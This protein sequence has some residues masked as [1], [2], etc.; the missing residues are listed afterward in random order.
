MLTDQEVEYAL[1][2][3][4]SKA[5]L[6]NNAAFLGSLLCSM[7]VIWKD[8]NNPTASTN[9]Q[10][11]WWNRDWFI[12]LPKETRVTVLVHELWHVGRLHFLRRGNRD[13]EIWN[14]ACDI[15]INNDLKAA[16]Y[17][18]KDIEWAWLMPELDVNGPMPEEDI[19]DHL[20]QNAKQPPPQPGEGGDGTGA[21]GDMNKDPDGDD[22]G[23]PTDEQA[24]K[25]NRMVEAVIRAQQAA[26]RANQAGSIPGGTKDWI[27]QFLT[28]KIKWETELMQFFTDLGEIRYTWARPNRRYVGQGE[29]RQSTEHESDRLEHLIYYLDVSGSIQ[30]KDRLRFNSEVKYIKDVLNPRKLT[31]VQFDTEIQHEHVFE[32]EDRFEKVVD[33]SGGGTCLVCVH[34][35]IVEHNPT[36]AIIFSD[37]HVSPMQKPVTGTPIIWVRIGSG[38]VPDFGKVINLR[39]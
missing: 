28:P 39:S 11:L 27:K 31:L 37:M 13:P 14:Y 33:V 12:S 24:A 19:Y 17:S 25:N 22:S 3:C 10:K 1:D 36:A 20:I 7:E 18:F 30:D 35:H 9:G 38:H 8:T 29:Y 26:E 21:K 16:G 5:F 23:T 2:A 34:D 6:G 32:E 4:K 15:R